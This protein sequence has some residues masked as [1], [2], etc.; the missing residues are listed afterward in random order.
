VGRT[1]S[2]HDAVAF[3]GT[4]AYLHPE[5]IFKNDEFAFTDS[6]YSASFRVIPIHKAPANLDPRVRAFDKAVS[7][8]RVKSEH[9]NGLLKGRF[10]S[11]KSLRIS[12]DRRRDH[13]RAMRWISACIILHNICVDV[14][15]DDWEDDEHERGEEEGNEEG[16]E[17]EE[18]QLA[19]GARRRALVEA[20]DRYR[21]P[22]LYQ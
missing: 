8:L 3:K 15:G 17:V 11:L 5:L 14:G 6:A 18:A 22:H 12:I 9:C 13:V 20:Y 19:G 2:A 1:G 7:R 4:A 21:H 10:Q 16:M